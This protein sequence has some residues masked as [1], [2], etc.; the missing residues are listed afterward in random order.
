M[1]ARDQKQTYVS[2]GVQN[3]SLDQIKPP[4]FVK[5]EQGSDYGQNR[6]EENGKMQNRIRQMT[7]EYENHE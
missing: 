7:N 6:W 3:Q 2:K 5:N 1:N 4:Q